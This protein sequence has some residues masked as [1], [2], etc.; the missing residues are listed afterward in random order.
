[1][2]SP[3]S[4]AARERRD[5]MIGTAPPARRWLLVEQPAGWGRAALK[6]VA[7]PGLDRAALGRAL[8]GAAARLQLIR[9][10]GERASR[11]ARTESARQWAVIDTEP[12]ARQ[13]WGSF[14]D[15]W[16]ALYAALTAPFST[17]RVEPVLLVCTNG[18]HD[19][20]CAVRGRPVAAALAAAYPDWTWETTHTG[21]DRFAA[22]LIV[23]PDGACYGGLD[24]DV[25]PVLVARHR[26]GEPDLAHLR[27][28]TGRSPQDQAA[29]LAV[30]AELGVVPW[31]RARLTVRTHV[32]RRPGQRWVREVFRDDIAVALVHG[33]NV[34][35]PAELLTCTATAPGRAAV[36]TVDEV[37]IRRHG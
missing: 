20:C 16:D 27:G 19:A 8:E 21:G 28:V 4:D 15:G 35:R 37:E 33:R 34:I 36:P 31:D 30:A 3:C 26:R 14:E 29:V 23:L 1:M 6:S 2:T 7:V 25:A 9:R 13:V 11:T 12:P 22:N 24:P 32:E 5:P 17:P 18:R 10:P